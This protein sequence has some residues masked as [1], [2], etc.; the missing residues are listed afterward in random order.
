MLSDDRDDET[1]SSR[2]RVVP[3]KSPISGEQSARTTPSGVAPSR[4]VEHVS[5]EHT[6][7]PALSGQR[8][9]QGDLNSELE[10]KIS[11]E[12]TSSEE[13]KDLHME[14]HS[15][16][17]A[18]WEWENEQNIPRNRH[19]EEALWSGNRAYTLNSTILL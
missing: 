2:E 7:K 8:D 18:D 19:C 14:E 12:G 9:P 3:V 6:G 17:G 1:P 5:V 10:A 16:G 11:G 4:E 15:E 13:R